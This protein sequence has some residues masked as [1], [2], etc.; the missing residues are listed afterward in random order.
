MGLVFVGIT[1]GPTILEQSR[2]QSL[3]KEVEDY[4]YG[5]GG[6]SVLGMTTTSLAETVATQISE[7]PRA[8]IIQYEVQPGDTVG[9]IAEKFGVS[10][11]TVYWENDLTEKSKLKPGD[12]IRVLPV[13]GVKHVV[14]RGETVHSIAKK[15]D[16]SP[17]GVVDYPYNTF[18]NDETFQ[19]A[20]GQA[21]VVPDGVKPDEVQVSPRR[22]L[23][24]QTPDAGTVVASGNWVWPAQ[25][26][27]TQRYVWYHPAIDVANNARPVV[28]AAD[29]GTVVAVSSIRWGYGNH[30]IIDHGNGF[31]TM[32]AHM[33]SFRVSQG[34]TV[35]KG[36]AVGVMGSS[37][38]STGIHL[39]FEVRRDGVA[40]NPLSYL[41]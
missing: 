10:E 9:Q 12:T 5:V 3:Q 31:Q 19:L 18:V 30:V 1:I 41:R 37:G 8:E 16:I 24:L 26:R 34:Q 17:Q 13:T 38:R 20:V 23:A 6:G 22:R 39:H 11:D 14:S 27:I 35:A 33:S 28:V 40:L 4:G 36:D 32:Y 2:Q 21:L 25:G 29:N 15:Y 7:K